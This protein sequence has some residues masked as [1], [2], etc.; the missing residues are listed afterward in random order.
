MS[1]FRRRAAVRLAMMALA[2]YA[3]LLMAGPV[4]HADLADHAKSSSHYCQLCAG[5]PLAARVEP[6][7][8][9]STPTL[10]AIGDVASPALAGFKAPV[11]F[12]TSGR[13]PPA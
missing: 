5:N 12:R 3:A 7:V 1:F 13:S 11:P 6:R 9:V 10:A 4:A 2:V 8:G